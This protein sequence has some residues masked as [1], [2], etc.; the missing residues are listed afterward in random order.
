M[1][2]VIPVEAQISKRKPLKTTLGTLGLH[3]SCQNLMTEWCDFIV[4]QSEA[5]MGPFIGPA[6]AVSSGAYSPDHLK[7]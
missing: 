4:S 1:R 5:I 3:L 6:W 2:H 7:V